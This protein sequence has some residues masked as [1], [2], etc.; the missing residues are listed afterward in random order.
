[1]RRRRRAARGDWL[2]VVCGKVCTRRCRRERLCGA[3]SGLAHGKICRRRRRRRCSFRPKSLLKVQRR[4][5]TRKHAFVF[6]KLIFLPAH[7]LFLPMTNSTFFSV[8]IVV[9]GKHRQQEDRA[10]PGKE[11]VLRRGEFSTRGFRSM[12]QFRV[13]QRP[14]GAAAGG[15]ASG[16]TR[17]DTYRFARKTSD[18]GPGAAAT[19]NRPADRP[20][21]VKFEIGRL[22]GTNGK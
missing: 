17:L 15:G 3:C 21:P 22:C 10:G 7:T 11:R 1:M 2:G 13:D 19:V 12:A 4:R 20:S 8:L 9:S 6:I 14:H 5:R 16:S 18:F